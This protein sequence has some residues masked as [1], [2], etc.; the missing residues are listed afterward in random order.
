MP[1]S[2]KM[3]IPPAQPKVQQG[4]VP[5]DVLYKL[6]VFALLTAIVPVTAYFGSVRYLFDGN[7]QYAALLAVLSANIVLF[8]YVYV[9]FREEK[10][11]AAQEKAA[12]SQ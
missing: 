10:A 4:G 5:N 11:A 2:G 7:T 6:V 1:A 8:S 12:K 9:A 3:A